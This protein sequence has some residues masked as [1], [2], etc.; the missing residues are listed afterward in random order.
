MPE[1]GG[2]Y[3]LHREAVRRAVGFLS[4][5][6]L[7]NLDSW[8][9]TNAHQSHAP[10]HIILRLT[11]KALKKEGEGTKRHKD[12][13]DLQQFI[14]FPQDEYQEEDGHES[15]AEHKDNRQPVWGYL[16]LR[17]E[18]MEDRRNWVNNDGPPPEELMQLGM[19]PWVVLHEAYKA[20]KRGEAPQIIPDCR[21][22]LDIVNYYSDAEEATRHKHKLPTKKDRETDVELP[23]LIEAGF[24][25]LE[26]QF[27]VL[28]PW[29][30]ILKR[31]V[32][33]TSKS[34]HPAHPRTV[35]VDGEEKPRELKRTVYNTARF[36]P[37]I[38]AFLAAMGPNAD[39]RFLVIKYGIEQVLQFK[40]YMR[41]DRETGEVYQWLPSEL[42][43]WYALHLLR[44]MFRIRFGC[45]M[46]PQEEQSGRMG[47]VRKSD[48]KAWRYYKNEVGKAYKKLKEEV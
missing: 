47:D 17:K 45:S 30:H 24:H 27:A 12:L 9:Y 22:V 25:K 18:D 10:F 1:W 41:T 26:D 32:L 28:L 11:L 21:W 36:N 40:P 38:T 13:T 7:R 37:M 19:E 4:R 43:E 35:R 34:P 6:D 2:K 16:K 46:F 31:T 14:C 42:H 15:E 44:R 20:H 39:D 33:A 3:L 23:K 5:D 29:T 8:S 48:D